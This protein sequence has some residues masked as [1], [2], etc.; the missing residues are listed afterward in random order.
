MRHILL[1]T[2]HW[3]CK[4]L[5]FITKSWIPL[6][7]CQARP[8][9]WFLGSIFCRKVLR[10]VLRENPVVLK[11]NS[12]ELLSVIQLI[13]HTLLIFL[14]IRCIYPVKNKLKVI[15]SHVSNKFVRRF[16]EAL[17]SCLEEVYSIVDAKKAKTGRPPLG[18]HF[19]LR[20][21]IWHKFFGRKD[22]AK[23]A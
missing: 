11:M 14:L 10:E 2:K 21:L 18:H 3:M 6:K 7:S 8:H 23:I 9:P 4:Q 19:Q 1:Q 22:V 5:F 12:F 17:D 16:F 20:F 13:E 15:L